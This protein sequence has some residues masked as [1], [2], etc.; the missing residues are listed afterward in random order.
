MLVWFFFG[1]SIL[2][3]FGLIAGQYSFGRMGSYMALTAQIATGIFLAERRLSFFKSWRLYRYFLLCI[4]PLFVLRFSP[5]ILQLIAG[6]APNTVQRYTA[7]AQHIPKEAVVLSDK[8]GGFPIP[9]FSGKL[10][11]SHHALAFV[12]DH[13]ER[14]EQVHRFFEQR[15]GEHK[16][17]QILEKY[18][19]SHVLLND[20]YFDFVFPQI[21]TS[22]EILNRLRGLVGLPRI[23]SASETMNMVMTRDLEEVRSYLEGIGEVIAKGEDWTLFLVDKYEDQRAKSK[24]Q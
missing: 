6:R 1:L 23:Y 24:N 11:C 19:V 12:P 8:Q 5:S 10:V 22:L 17:K 9:S 4:L 20:R 13:E 14:R 21:P 16:R 3:C 15:T 18:A 7:I 2:Y